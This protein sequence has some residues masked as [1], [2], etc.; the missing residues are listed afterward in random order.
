MRLTE[1]LIDLE[2]RLTEILDEVRELKMR[3]YA[4]EDQNQQLRAKLYAKKSQGEGF[5]NL[6]RLYEEGFHICPA[7]F[8][9][10]R[11]EGEDC[12]FCLGFLHR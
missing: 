11:N 8:A 4:L 2:N 9:T 10:A 5:D 1:A 12:L 6:A 3:V 7:H